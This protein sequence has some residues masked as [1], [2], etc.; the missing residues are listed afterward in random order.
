MTCAPRSAPA[1]E[2]TESWG[3]GCL[4]LKSDSLF[5]RW[6]VLALGRHS[7]NCCLSASQFGVETDL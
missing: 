1:G 4:A 6:V 7:R 3:V 5:M 2:Q